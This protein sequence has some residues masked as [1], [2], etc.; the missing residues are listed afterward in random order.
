MATFAELDEATKLLKLTR[1]EAVKVINGLIEQ[2]AE[3]GPQGLPEV[4]YGYGH[5]FRIAFVVERNQ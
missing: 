3:V 5:G 4:T 1:E 2:L